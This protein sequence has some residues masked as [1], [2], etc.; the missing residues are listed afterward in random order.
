MAANFGHLTMIML[1]CSVLPGERPSIRRVLNLPY[2]THSHLLPI[3]ADTIP[4]FDEICKRSARFITSCLFSPSSLV[5]SAAWHSVVFGKFSSPLRS[6]AMLYVVF[7]MAG[8]STRL[9]WTWYRY[10]TASLSFGIDIVC[11]ILRFTLQCLC[12]NW[13]L[14]EKA[15]LLY[16]VLQNLKLLF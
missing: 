5:Q 9:F 4:I 10:L 2:N 1:I 16:L 12:W 8:H 3:L 7:V 13:F 6:R 14:S 15:S 11:L